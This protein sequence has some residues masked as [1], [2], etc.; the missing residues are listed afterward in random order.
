MGLIRKSESPW[1]PQTAAIAGFEALIVLGAAQEIHE[2]HDIFDL[3]LVLGCAA[4]WVH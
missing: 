1:L 4:T 2:V 3:D